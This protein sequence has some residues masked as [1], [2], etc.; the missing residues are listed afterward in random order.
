M[1]KSTQKRGYW[2]PYRGD[3]LR[4]IR[5]RLRESET[6]QTLVELKDTSE[7]DVTIRLTE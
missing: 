3:M 7:G 2:Y 4:S 5:W 6:T 1:T